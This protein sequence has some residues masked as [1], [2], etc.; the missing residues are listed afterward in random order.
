M[1]EEFVDCVKGRIKGPSSV[2]LQALHEVVTDGFKTKEQI[3]QNLTEK[4]V[5]FPEKKK[6]FDNAIKILSSEYVPDPVI[7]DDMKM[8]DLTGEPPRF[9]LLAKKGCEL[10]NHMKDCIN[11]STGGGK[12]SRKNKYR[13]KKT[14]KIYKKR[15]KKNKSKRK[16]K[17]SKRRYRK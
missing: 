17:K 15:S 5:R 12:R 3:I 1:S 2:V 4:S 14:K 8:N 9:N 13:G 7:D 10:Y 11:G 6:Q 16:T